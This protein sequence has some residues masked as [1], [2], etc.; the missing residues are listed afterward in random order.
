MNVIFL[1]SLSILSYSAPK[2]KDL[3][4]RFTIQEARARGE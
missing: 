2:V 4:E 1:T 3:S